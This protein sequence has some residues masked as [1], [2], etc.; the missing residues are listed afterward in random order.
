MEEDEI[1]VLANEIKGKIFPAKVLLTPDKRDR[2]LIVAFTY[3]GKLIKGI[4]P[5]DELSGRI[6][7][8][9]KDEEIKAEVLGYDVK[10]ENI[11]LSENKAILSEAGSKK[12]GMSLSSLFDSL[13][14]SK[15]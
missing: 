13:S 3:N 4:I 2:F 8:Y 14:N 5:Q 11:I 9:S 7:N 15:K 1:K 10:S 6:T 12:S